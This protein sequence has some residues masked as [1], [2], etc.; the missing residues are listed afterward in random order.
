VFLTNRVNPTRENTAIQQIRPA[1]HDA[2]L[3][4]LA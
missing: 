2:V 1:L 3:T 4:A